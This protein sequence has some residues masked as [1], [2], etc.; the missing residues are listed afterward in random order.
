MVYV[1][2]K[3][4]SVKSGIK[5]KSKSLKDSRKSLPTP[6]EYFNRAERLNGRVAMIGYPAAVATEIVTNDSLLTQLNDVGVPLAVATAAIVTVGSLVK[7]EEQAQDS[8][9]FTPYA[10]LT[11]GRFAMFGL[12]ALIFTELTTG[13]TLF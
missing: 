2:A 8:D 5:S 9:I 6:G 13:S 3:Q 4:A 11:N 12:G 7:S 10:D 1:I